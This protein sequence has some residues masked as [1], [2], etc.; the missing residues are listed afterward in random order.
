MKG[1]GIKKAELQDLPRVEDRMTFLY[2]EHCKVNRTD[3]AITTR[4][5]K[6]SID[7]PAASLSVLLLGPGTDI[8]HRAMELIAHNGV[9]VIW[10]GEQ[11]VRFYAH[12]NPLSKSSS[13]IVQQ[14]KLVSN[15]RSRIAVARKMYQIRFPDEDVS[16][17]SM[18]QLRGREGARVRAVYRELAKESGVKWSGRE[19]NSDDYEGGDPVNQALSAGNACLYGLAHSVSSALGLSP[20]LG[21]VHSGHSDSFIYDL[22]DLYKTETSIPL[23][24]ELAADPTKDIGSIMRH[25]MRDLFREQQLVKQMIKDVYYLLEDDKLELTD[26]EIDIVQLWDD[27][28]GF[29]DSGVMY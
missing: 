11:G 15:T 14:A 13:L 8:S 3:G 16:N 6:G 1:A 12:G 23:A 21:F 2:V 25:R 9:T 19:F 22:A 29:V 24:F 5:V 4:T 28:K 10:V 18:Q 17:L 20:A 27:K 7:V 26:P